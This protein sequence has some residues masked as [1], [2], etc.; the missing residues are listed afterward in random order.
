MSIPPTLKEQETKPEGVMNN[1]P[2]I[3]ILTASGVNE[4]EM[5][6]IQRALGANRQRGHVVTP[7]NGLIHSWGEGTW[8]HCYPSDAK[9]EVSLGADFDMLVLPGG[10]RHVDKLL[11]NPH[12]R[13]FVTSFFA[14]N[15][16]VAAY[17]D[18]ARILETNG[19][20]G[21]NAVVLT[22]T[23]AESLTA[24]A[25][26]MMAHFETAQHNALAEAA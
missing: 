10:S 19:F 8:G 5:T 11:A 1:S 9:L 16:P 12:T 13:R 25:A 21:D 23:D 7:E 3:A 2:K 20:A 17:G 4:I 15:K 18:A 24:A 6:A 26:Q 14:M 22:Y